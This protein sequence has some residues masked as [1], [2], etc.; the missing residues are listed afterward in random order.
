LNRERTIRSSRGKSYT[1]INKAQPE[2]FET[3]K[4]QLLG[5]IVEKHNSV[6]Y[7]SKRDLFNFRTGEE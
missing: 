6:A 2:K 5:K 4:S 7:L 1:T 3:K